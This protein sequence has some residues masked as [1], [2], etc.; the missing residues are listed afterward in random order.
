MAFSISDLLDLANG[1]N[2]FPNTYVLII[3]AESDS[4]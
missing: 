1:F 2:A 3:A 4:C